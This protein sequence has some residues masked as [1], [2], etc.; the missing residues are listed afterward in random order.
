MATA[1][2]NDAERKQLSML[3]SAEKRTLVWLAHRLPSW[4]NSDHLTLLGFLAMF[5]AGLCY[6]LSRYDRRALLL[7]IAALVVNWFGDSL[8]APWHA[9]ATGSGRGTVSTWTTSPTRSAL[10]FS[11][12][13]WRSRAT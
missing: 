11:W 4:V 10:R 12:A 13:V 2:F 3:A 6:W 5:A 7:V 1:T 9:C 8:E